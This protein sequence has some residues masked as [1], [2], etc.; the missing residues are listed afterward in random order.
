M[1]KLLCRRYWQAVARQ[2]KSM[3]TASLSLHSLRAISQASRCVARLKPPQ[4]LQLQKLGHKMHAKS[5]LQEILALWSVA[6]GGCKDGICQGKGGKK[7]AK[8]KTGNKKGK[9]QKQGKQKEKMAPAGFVKQWK[10]IEMVFSVW[11]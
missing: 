5:P 9:K 6:E 3:R 7:G 4:G 8:T 2:R 10:S 11:G 1:Y